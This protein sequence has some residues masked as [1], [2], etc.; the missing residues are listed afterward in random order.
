MVKNTDLEKALTKWNECT[1]IIL[2][3]KEKHINEMSKKLSNPQAAPKTHRKI[4]NRFLSNKKM[5]SIPS[6]L[7]NRE[8]ISNW[9]KKPGLFSKFFASQC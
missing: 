5:P 8:M 9:L 4:L 3:A 6:L 7:L 2:G 1:E